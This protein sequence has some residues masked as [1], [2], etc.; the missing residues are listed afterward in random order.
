M[1]YNFVILAAE[2]PPVV[3]LYDEM[4]SGPF[5][6]YLALSKKIGGH[7]DEMVNF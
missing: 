2:A 7:V 3:K 6:E 5:S 4:L 1:Y